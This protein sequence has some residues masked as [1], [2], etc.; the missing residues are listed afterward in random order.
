MEIDYARLFE[1]K[2]LGTTVWSPLASG[3]LTGKYNSGIPERSR[4]GNHS[5]MKHYYDK[6]LGADKK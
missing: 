3:V 5:D 4:F 6:Y 1:K 2:K